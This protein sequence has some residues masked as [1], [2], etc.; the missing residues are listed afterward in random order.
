MGA[1]VFVILFSLATSGTVPRISFDRFLPG[2]L[3]SFRAIAALAL[4]TVACTSALR[5]PP[6]IVGRWNRILRFVCAIIWMGSW[7]AF[8]DIEGDG[9]RQPTS[10]SGI[11]TVGTFLFGGERYLT[12]LQART[13]EIAQLTMM[14]STFGFLVFDWRIT[15][16]QRAANEA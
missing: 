5:T 8:I 14:L 6:E 16:R 3:W 9:Y 4:F 11:Y 12:P 13:R 10:A 7:L 1:V 15:R 2:H